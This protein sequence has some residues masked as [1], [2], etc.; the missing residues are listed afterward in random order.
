MNRR[1]L[2]TILFVLAALTG[3]QN[4]LLEFEQASDPTRVIFQVTVADSY[5]QSAIQTRGTPQTSITAYEKD[6]ITVQALD[7]TSGVNSKKDFTVT[8]SRS[9]T[10][11]VYT[12]ERQYNGLTYNFYAYASDLEPITSTINKNGLRI[13][14][15]EAGGDSIA[16]TVPNEITKQPD[17]LI[18]DKIED[19]NSGQVQLKLHHALACVGFVAS[20]KHVDNTRKVK[21]VK[22][23]R[24]YKSGAVSII[25]NPNE[26]IEWFT[27]GDT[28]DVS[29]EAGMNDTTQLGGSYDAIK[30]NL[31]YLMKGDGYLM[32]VPQTLPE[33]AQV[34]MKIWD[35]INSSSIHTITYDIPPTTWESGKKYMYYFDEPILEGAAT[36]YERYKDGTYGFYYYDG[37]DNTSTVTNT[38][39]DATKNPVIVDAGYGLLVPASVYTQYPSIYLGINNGRDDPKDKSTSDGNIVAQLSVFTGTPVDCVLYPL[40][41]DNYPFSRTATTRRGLQPSRTDVPMKIEAGVSE[42][43]SGKP[44]NT[45]GYFLPHYAKGVYTSSSIP[46]SYSIRS[47]IQVR[48]IS[49]QTDGSNGAGVTTKKTYIQEFGTL[50]FS[51]HN[52]RTIYGNDVKGTTSYKESIVIGGFGG[53]FDGAQSPSGTAVIA[54]LI[55]STPENHPHDIALFEWVTAGGKLNNI[56]TAASCIYTATQTTAK[57]YIAGI[58]ASNNGLVEKVVNRASITNKSTSS[59]EVGGIVGL[60]SKLMQ[61]CENYGVVNNESSNISSR[62]GGIVAINEMFIKWAELGADAKQIFRNLQDK[63]FNGDIMGH[64]GAVI[65]NCKNHARIVGAGRTGGITAYNNSGGVIYQCTNIGEIRNNGK[66][67]SEIIL[68][69]IVGLQQC[70]EENNNPKDPPKFFSVIQECINKGNVTASSGALG[71]TNL[72]VGGIVGNNDF[73]PPQEGTSNEIAAYGKV[74]RCVV[75]GAT[76]SGYFSDTG[77]IAGLNSGNVNRSLCTQVY[78]GGT[79]GQGQGRNSAGGIVG[80]NNNYVGSCLFEHS[81]PTTPIS[82]AP[83]WSGSSSSGGIVGINNT[84]SNE[85]KSS[86]GYV[87]KCIFAAQAPKNVRTGTEIGT[88]AP[89]AGFSGGYL[90]RAYDGTP[91]LRDTTEVDATTG[92]T[93]LYTLDDNYYGSGK[94]ENKEIN[95]TNENVT[96]PNEPQVELDKIGPFISGRYPYGQTRFQ[97]DGVNIIPVNGWF[98]LNGFET[99]KRDSRPPIPYGL[100]AGYASHNYFLPSGGGALYIQKALIQAIQTIQ[101]SGNPGEASFKPNGLKIAST[102]R[103]SLNYMSEDELSNITAITCDLSDVTFLSNNAGGEGSLFFRAPPGWKFDPSQTNPKPYKMIVLN[104]DG[105]KKS[106]YWYSLV[107]SGTE[108]QIKMVKETKP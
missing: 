44:V 38:I 4:E 65:Y 70:G 24:V 81:S 86:S 15:S 36:Y 90:Y 79:F 76:I 66:C 107:T 72:A 102:V 21:S 97:T 58:A 22:I 91:H 41:Q 10:A 43:G 14:S 92:A 74:N 57:S 100:P 8:L 77:G 6:K 85:L 19:K 2:Y 52:N 1:T 101:S 75:D 68:G 29:L 64:P 99:W 26:A 98:F 51:I 94:I 20:S 96:F 56:E 63:D 30:D 83:M 28:A 93:P 80:T 25:K 60:N 61:D 27:S 95:F 108:R 46:T 88:F 16:Y 35:G 3:C 69:G 7:L 62:T 45:H 31:T 39:M 59:M 105:S 73:A 13:F 50:D 47:P 87:Q 32:M 67:T 106:H 33:G 34:I 49:Y 53:T 54:G 17:L 40:S 48:N 89:I 84:N 9:G 78:V 11:W 104:D 42:T 71:N 18:A 5:P 23:T 82:E 37:K 12:P 55:I 103:V